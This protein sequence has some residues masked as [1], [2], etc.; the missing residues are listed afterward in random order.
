[1]RLMLLVRMEL[2]KVVVGPA[3][4]LLDYDQ[5]MEVLQLSTGRPK[6]TDTLEKTVYLRVKNNK[7]S[8]L[9]KVQTKDYVNVQ[10]KVSYCVEFP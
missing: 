5:T 9:I 4:K 3:T 2:E 8:D 10:I 1:M 6:T 7:V